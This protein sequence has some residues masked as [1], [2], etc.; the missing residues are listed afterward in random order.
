[1]LRAGLIDG[2][3][4]TNDEGQPGVKVGEDFFLLSDGGGEKALNALRQLHPQLAVSKQKGGAGDTGANGANG[5]KGGKA[6]KA[7]TTEQYHEQVSKG[8]DLTKFFAEGG[9]IKDE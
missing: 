4:T 2:V 3:I 9:I 8:T 6:E 1:V 5:G 7:M